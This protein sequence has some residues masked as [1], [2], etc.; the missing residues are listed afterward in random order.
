MVQLVTPAP[1]LE[2][3]CRGRL[4]GLDDEEGCMLR[5]GPSVAEGLDVPRPTA[6][7]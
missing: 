2:T 1:G 4:V 5:Q 7:S 3:A 6:I